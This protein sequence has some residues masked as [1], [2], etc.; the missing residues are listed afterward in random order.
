MKFFAIRYFVVKSSLTI[1]QLE[2]NKKPRDLFIDPLVNRN[3]AKY[4]K[5]TYTTR[6]L[7]KSPEEDLL[8]GYLLKSKDTHLI[9]LDSELFDEEDIK[10]WEK[11][12]FTIDLEKQII[13]IEH[14]AH[15]SSPENVLNVLTKLTNQYSNKFGYEVKLE[16][17]VDKFAFWD[18]VEKSSGIYQIG[19]DLN[20]P[21][22]FGGS[23][24]ANEWLKNLKEKHNMSKITFDIRNENGELGYEEDELES[25]RDYADSGG[26][27]WTLGILQDGKKRKFKSSNHLRRKELEFNSED[28]VKL[29]QQLEKTKTIL[30]SLIDV[31]DNING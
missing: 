28:P 25:Y 14:Q 10:N 13:A 29:I 9:K 2:A 15:V 27:N 12:F 7:N 21:N 16:F 11:L 19:F 18:I 30:K 23:K 17:L 4:Y 24:K 20:A 31:L 26:G 6:V 22:L 3:E 8:I 5:R 1:F